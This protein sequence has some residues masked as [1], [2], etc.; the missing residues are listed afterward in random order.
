M[1][2]AA[3]E[4]V[5]ADRES[6]DGLWPRKAAASPELESARAIDG[7]P[8]VEVEREG[9]RE[10]KSGAIAAPIYGIGQVGY[11]EGGIYRTGDVRVR[12]RSRKKSERS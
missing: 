4:R 9:G 1:T 2:A 3:A 7:E 6:G 11:R 8:D 10:F 12:K 5:V